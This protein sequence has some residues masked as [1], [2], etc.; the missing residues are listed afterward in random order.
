MIL[1]R[2]ID[3]FPGRLALSNYDSA[4]TKAIDRGNGR[5]PPHFLAPLWV[6]TEMG[7]ECSLIYWRKNVFGI[8]CSERT[9]RALFKN[10]DVLGFRGL[11]IP[12]RRMRFIRVIVEAPLYSDLKSA[13]SCI[14]SVSDLMR[15]MMRE[16]G[17]G[18]ERLE[19]IIDGPHTYA[20]TLQEA[21]QRILEP[22]TYLS[23]I[24]DALSFSN[25][26]PIYAQYLDFCI[27]KKRP[28]SPLP[29]MYNA[30]RRYALLFRDAT[31]SWRKEAC[32]CMELGDVKG[33]MQERDRLIRG[34]T[35]RVEHRETALYDFET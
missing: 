6:C 5:P 27:M 24:T 34:V 13:Q 9:I 20:M 7:A 29:K 10:H 12:F 15:V 16:H 35:R 23:G 1:P 2:P 31:E 21:S 26:P 11:H 17:M 14:Q 19:L 8:G 4:K 3:D 28:Q 33:F 25:V 18:L 22:F 32:I 30:L